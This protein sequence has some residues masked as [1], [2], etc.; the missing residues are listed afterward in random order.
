MV[1]HC[2]LM[3]FWFLNNIVGVDVWVLG[4]FFKLTI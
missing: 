3:I 1:T 4:G 2:F